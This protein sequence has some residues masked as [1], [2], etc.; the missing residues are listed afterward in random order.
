MVLITSWL[1]S[2]RKAKVYVKGMNCLLDITRT[3]AIVAFAQLD[4]VFPK[5]LPS[6]KCSDTSTQ[7]AGVPSYLN[8]SEFY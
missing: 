7:Q 2:H 1:S 6:S 8:T 5:S 4:N 3:H